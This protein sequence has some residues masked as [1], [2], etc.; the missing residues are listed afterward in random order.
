MCIFANARCVGASRG[1]APHA[2][3]TARAAPRACRCARCPVVRH[4]VGA[5]GAPP[6]PACACRRWPLDEGRRRGP[7]PQGPGEGPGGLP[8]APARLPVPCAERLS[9][10]SPAASTPH[11]PRRRP[12]RST[13]VPERGVQCSAVRGAPN[14]AHIPPTHPPPP[15]Q[16]V[17][18]R[19][20][21]W[22][23]RVSRS[24]PGRGHATRRAAATG[25]GCRSRSCRR[26][27]RCGRPG[28]MRRT[29]GT[30]TRGGC[31]WA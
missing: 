6:G 31:R 19:S 8:C 30:R 12:R 20:V 11:A 28:R 26:A 18:R 23:R 29:G 16:R 5:C 15:P 17:A 9:P 14:P 1:D 24:R 13:R 27:G 22:R 3:R 21:A 25:P 10:L 2:A 7:S 4:G